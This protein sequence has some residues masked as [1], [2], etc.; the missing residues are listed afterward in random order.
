MH[1]NQN[2][3]C[4]QLYNV[5][6]KIEG[7]GGGTNESLKSLKGINFMYYKIQLFYSNRSII[8]S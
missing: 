3:R 1:T 8:V 7:E 6:N 2:T 4:T 5:I